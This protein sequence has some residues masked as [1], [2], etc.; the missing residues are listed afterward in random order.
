MKPLIK[1]ARDEAG[2]ET[3]EYAIMAG[4]VV[5]A[6]VAIILAVGAWVK[7]T[8]SNMQTQLP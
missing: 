8:Y 5:G 6:S 7:S 2:L 3:V 1:F 4:L